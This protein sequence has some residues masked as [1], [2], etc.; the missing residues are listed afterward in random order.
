LTNSHLMGVCFAFDKKYYFSTYI[1]NDSGNKYSST[2]IVAAITS[3]IDKVEIPTHIYINDT[4]C[5]L[6][7][8]SLVLLEQIRTIDHSRL[9]NYCG[10]L[11]TSIMIMINEALYVSV[12]LPN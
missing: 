7:K 6:V 10:S 2:V 4:S 12:G 9:L 3:K 11:S 1:Q 5:G 8:E